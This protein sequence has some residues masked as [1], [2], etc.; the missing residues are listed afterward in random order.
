[1]LLQLGSVIDGGL[2][3]NFRIGRIISIF[4]KRFYGAFKDNLDLMQVLDVWKMQ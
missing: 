3:L 2:W 1:M 4:Q